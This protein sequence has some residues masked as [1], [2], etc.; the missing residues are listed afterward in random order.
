MFVPDCD[1]AATKLFAGRVVPE[2]IWS[3]CKVLYRR[4]E[5]LK[6]QNI[7]NRIIIF[8]QRTKPQIILFHC[9]T[10]VASSVLLNITSNLNVTVFHFRWHKI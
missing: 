3:L 1:A 5:M 10:N 8:F 6:K 9:N 4:A 2:G 7:L